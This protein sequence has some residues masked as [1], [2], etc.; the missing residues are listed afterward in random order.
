M[1][2]ILGTLQTCT[3]VHL[4]RE[5][6]PKDAFRCPY[7]ARPE[8]SNQ[9]GINSALLYL[10]CAYHRYVSHDSGMQPSSVAPT[11][12]TSILNWQSHQWLGLPS[13]CPHCLEVGGRN[14]VTCRYSQLTYVGRRVVL[15]RPGR[16]LGTEYPW[17][18]PTPGLKCT[19]PHK[20]TGD[21]LR[22]CMYSPQAVNIS[23][24]THT[25]THTQPPSS[26]IL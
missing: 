15:G 3:S 24:P 20:S 26:Y 9:A 25:H 4:V 19:D 7:K 14:A 6:W 8:P 13:H 21:T 16:M 23:T 22:M 12:T 1:D 10:V 5:H 11:G 17:P 18:M 2:T